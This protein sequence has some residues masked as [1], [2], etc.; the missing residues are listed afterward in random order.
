[1]FQVFHLLQSAW[2]W[3]DVFDQ[4]S[5]LLVRDPDVAAMAT[6][7]VNPRVFAQGRQLPAELTVAPWALRDRGHGWG[8]GHHPSGPVSALLGNSR[9][10]RPTS[11]TLYGGFS[12]GGRF[13]RGGSWPLER[14][15]LGCNRRRSVSI[16]GRKHSGNQR[17]RR[18]IATLLASGR[19]TGCAGELLD[20]ASHAT[21]RFA[22]EAPG[23]RLAMTRRIPDLEFW[24]GTDRVEALG[25]RRAD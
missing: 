22:T 13:R 17:E 3:R 4:L 8:N 5:R 19:G 6:V 10:V 25:N 24:R 1:M 23:N 16:D 20:A 14:M 18:D 21:S 12:D 2:K 11:T 7:V 15:A 9:T